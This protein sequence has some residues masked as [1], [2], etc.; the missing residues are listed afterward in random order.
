ME[1]KLYHKWMCPYSAK[2]RDFIEERQLTDQVQ[3][4]DRDENA[5]NKQSLKDLTGKTQVPCLL[6]DGKPMLESEEI[7][8]FLDRQFSSS[9][10]TSLKP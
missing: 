6:I 1:L 5:E 8:N 9:S 4:I 10:Q 2:V 7:V 3:Y